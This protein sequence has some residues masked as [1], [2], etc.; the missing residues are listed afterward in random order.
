MHSQR[1]ARSFVRGLEIR[2]KSILLPRKVVPFLEFSSD[3]AREVFALL[4]HK[5]EKFLQLVR[6]VLAGTTVSILTL[7]RLVGKCVSLSLAVPAALLFTRAM[8]GAIGQS[9]RLV[10][11]IPVQGLLKDEIAHWLFLENWDDPLPWRDE[12][13]VRLKIASDAS[14]SGWGGC[15]V[16]PP[17]EVNITDYWT[18]QEQSW[19][20]CL[21]EAVALERTLLAV[22]DRV[23]NARVDALVDNMVVVQAWVH[24]GKRSLPLSRVLKSLFFTTVRLNLSLRLTYIPTDE[25]PADGPS[26]RLSMGDWKLH[27]AIWQI[28]QDRF[29]GVSGHSCDFMALDSNAMTDGHGNVLPHFTPGPS[30][31]SSGTNFFCSRFILIRSHVESSVYFPSIAF[32]W[33]GDAFPSTPSS[34]MH[35]GYI[36]CLPPQVLVAFTSTICEGL[37]VFS[38]EGMRTSFVCSLTDWMDPFLCIFGRFVGICYLF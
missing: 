19:D 29:G 37:C 2:L 24:Q 4:P 10:R 38:C 36:R 22:Q 32:G 33:G 28:V 5:K 8:N 12:R 14:G 9:H 13:H 17:P 16:S 11:P 20:I 3:S 27:P 23:V 1:A 30:P 18:P 31:K 21:K 35:S 26:R 6:Q 34:V 15:I 7:Q 25:N